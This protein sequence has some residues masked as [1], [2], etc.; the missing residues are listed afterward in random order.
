MRQKL[1]TLCPNSWDKAIKKTNFSEWVRN[2]LLSERNKNEAAAVIAQLEKDIE[3]THARSEKW[4]ARC[5]DYMGQV[6][7]LKLKMGEEE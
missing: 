6:T 3:E 7:S 4:Y 1:I 2:Q 5:M